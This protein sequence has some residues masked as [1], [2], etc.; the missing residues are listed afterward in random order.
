MTS[1]EITSIRLENHQIAGTKFQK[2]Q[3]LV[4]WM[5]AMQ[6]QDY[7]MSKWA[8]GVRLPG[9]HDDMV[10][11]AFDKGEIVRT[12]LLRPT[13]HIV[14][15]QDIYWILGLTSPHIKP[16]L[17]PRHRDLELTESI[18]KKSKSVIGKLLV[19]GNH[20]TREE[21][22]LQLQNSGISTE[23]QR[24]SHLMLT[25]ELDGLVCSGKTNGQKQTYTLLEEWVPK[26]N[27]FSREEALAKLA[28]RYFSSHGPATIQDFIWWSGLPVKD[29]KNA[30][31][32][33]KSEFS[34]AIIDERIYWFPATNRTT[35]SK[36]ASVY[37]LP[38]YDEFII[39]YRDRSDSLHSLDH[40]KAISENGL[41]RPVIVV[42]G[43]VAGIW[44]RRQ[45]KDRLILIPEYFR[46]VST[47]EQEQIEIAS[48]RY[49][50]FLNSEVELVNQIKK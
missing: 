16:I 25:A 29:A 20:L 37:L 31:E 18:I 35:Q 26:T 17:R 5:G 22:M 41:F 50:Q 28:S 46:P 9:I 44:K 33:V 12:H 45:M 1:E 42:N 10:T 8:I 47:K 43:K 4:S 49:G 36:N 19:G 13:W 40:K 48:K 27:L 21:I 6:A 14:S 24:A 32:M 2:V 23:G 3:E 15:S 38:A 11:E 7:S 30:L 34:S 39:S